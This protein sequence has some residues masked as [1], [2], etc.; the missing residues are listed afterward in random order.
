L[1]KLSDVAIEMSWREGPKI[2]VRPN[3]HGAIVMQIMRRMRQ[4]HESGKKTST[5]ADTDRLADTSD[6]IAALEERAAEQS[7]IIEALGRSQAMIE[8][9]LDGTIVTAN[10]NFLATMATAWPRSRASI[11]ACSPTTPTRTAPTTASSGKT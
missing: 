6:R 10:E 3:N 2:W 1:T 11:T 5:A 8:F 9:E 7:A 4:D